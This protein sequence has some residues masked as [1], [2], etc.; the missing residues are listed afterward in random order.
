MFTDNLTEVLK[1]GGVAVM[2]TDTI[3]GIV[4]SALN[5]KTI[6]RIYKIKKRSPE[7]KL[8]TLIG[9]WNEIKKFGIDVGQFQIPPYDKPTTFIL[10]DVSFRLPL[11]SQFREFLIKTGP[12]AAPSANPEGLPP[13]TNIA[14]A[15]EYFG[16]QVDLYVD[17]G[18]LVGKASQIIRLHPDGSTTI[19]RS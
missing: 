9:D 14:E 8:I 19:I 5:L 6:E 3:Y 10:E 16:D 13:A 17:G 4:G 1:N 7:K 12:L 11:D 2:P 18:T 15:K